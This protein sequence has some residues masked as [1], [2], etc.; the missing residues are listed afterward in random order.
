MR[1]T[2]ADGTYAVLSRRLAGQ[3]LPAGVP[4]PSLDEVYPYLCQSYDA[5]GHATHCSVLTEGGVVRLLQMAQRKQWKV[6]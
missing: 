1:I 2:A 3:P 6:E 4:T 5:Q